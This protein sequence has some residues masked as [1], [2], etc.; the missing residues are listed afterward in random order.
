MRD[1]AGLLAG[2][3]QLSDEF[4]QSAFEHGEFVLFG[5]KL[6]LGLDFCRLTLL[7]YARRVF[8]FG[9]R[10]VDPIPEFFLLPKVLF[11]A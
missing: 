5:S 1:A 7:F 3:V 9:F 8:E 6:L 10:V 4:I 11:G 2:I